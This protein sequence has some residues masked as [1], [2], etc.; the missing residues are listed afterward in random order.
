M[1]WAAIC[2]VPVLHRSVS[3]IT[4]TI[5]AMS[6]EGQ[7]ETAAKPAAVSLYLQQ[8]FY[9]HIIYISQA[10]KVSIIAVKL[11]IGGPI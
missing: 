7:K 11:A 2:T 8:S 9:I 6:G 1:G 4:A 10:A 5:A 3:I